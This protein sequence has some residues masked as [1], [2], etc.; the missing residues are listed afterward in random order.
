MNQQPVEQDLSC[1]GTCKYCGKE[2]KG[3]E[4]DQC[5]ECEAL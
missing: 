2:L 4:L 5:E 3:D 1:E